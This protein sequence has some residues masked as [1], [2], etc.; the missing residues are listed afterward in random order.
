MALSHLRR[1]VIGLV[2]AMPLAA[3]L[4]TAATA[5]P[6]ARTLYYDTS[7]AGEYAK[8]WD[9]AA[10]V[11]NNSVKNVKLA[12][13]TP[14]NS[15]IKILVDDGWPRAQPG[16]LGSGRVWM[17]RTAV[18]Q[19]YY[20]PRIATHELGHILGLPDRKPGPCSSLMSG[21]TGGVSCK[22]VPPNAAEAAEVDRNF[23]G[24]RM[25]EAS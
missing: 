16:A 18:N 20:V 11:W 13:G 17:G 10:V 8:A 1:A 5:A 6:V 2:V 25:A 24:S 4:Q 19:G 3:G 22:S 9:D 14:A 21:S 23:G 12:K 15:S 7:Q